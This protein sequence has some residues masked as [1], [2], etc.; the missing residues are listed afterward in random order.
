MSKKKYIIDEMSFKHNSRIYHPGDIIELDDDELEPFEGF[1]LEITEDK[2]KNKKRDNELLAG[3][4]AEIVSLRAQIEEKDREILKYKG[5]YDESLED[6]KD[7]EKVNHDI[8]DDLEAK[9]NQ[10][11]QEEQ[12][13]QETEFN[14]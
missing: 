3:L 8:L 14:L 7:L 10:E 13:E 11:E 4:E 6:I 9:L 12:E 5:L 2:K 1:I